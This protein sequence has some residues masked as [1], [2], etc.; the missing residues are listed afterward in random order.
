MPGV[1]AVENPCKIILFGDSILK[2]CADMFREAITSTF[3]DV[4]MTVINACIEGET[5][6]DG[7]DRLDNIISRRPDVVVVGFGMNDWRKGVDSRCFE[8][9]LSTIIDRMNARGVRTIATTIMPDYVGFPGGTSDEIGEY[10]VIIRTVAAAKRV[11]IADINALWMREMRPLWL[12]LADQNHP[13][14]RGRSLIVRSLMMVVPR[15]QTTVLWAFDGAAVPCNYSC[16]YCYDQFLPS[17]AHRY[18][19]P[20]ARWHDA[21]RRALGKQSVVFYISYG[22]P[23]L[24]KGFNDVTGMIASEPNWVMMMTSNLSQPLDR[25]TKSRL[26]REGKLNINASFHPTQTNIG[27]FLEKLFLLRDCGIE[28]PVI[29]VMYP[30]MIKEFGRYFGIFAKHGFLVHVRAFEGVY[31]GKAYPTGYREHE[32]RF[33]AKYADDATVKYMLNRPPFWEVGK[34]AYHGMHYI[35]VTAKGDAMTQFFGSD[36]FT[37]SGHQYGRMLG[38]IFDGSLKLDTLPQPLTHTVERSVTDVA[39]ILETGYNELEGNFVASFSRQGGVCHSNRGVLYSNLE[40]DFGNSGIR[41][42][43]NF[44]SAAT[45]IRDYFGL[46]MR[47]ASIRSPY[48]RR[49]LIQKVNAKVRHGLQ[50]TP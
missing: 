47:A 50:A 5:S 26:V 7:R 44:P 43:Y 48:L 31:D 14:T 9:N 28:C 12:G 42:D 37:S 1:A 39:A 16:Q 40:V 33:I 15:N 22:E 17:R 46:L 30:P 6:T 13:N 29:Y 45:V 36:E 10:N 38:N 8:D 23:M 4:E 41:R 21:F 34:F 18:R 27:P 20:I 19:G 24:S 35:Y 25:L 2:S 32:R 49:H 11:R 3:P